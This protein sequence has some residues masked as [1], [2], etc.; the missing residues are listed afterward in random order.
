LVQQAAVDQNVVYSVEGKV[1]EQTVKYSN[2]SRDDNDSEMMA[3]TVP[4]DNE[5]QTPLHVAHQSSNEFK[6]MIETGR[7]NDPQMH[8]V[9]GRIVPA[10]LGIIARFFVQ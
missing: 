3:V 2:A 8:D 1:G 7:I 10:L 5:N 9:Q 6:R 4:L